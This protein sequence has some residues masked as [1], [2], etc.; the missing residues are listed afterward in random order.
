MFE[1]V[2]RV[3]FGRYAA[4]VDRFRKGP[5]E[6]P[7]S[8]SWLVSFVAARDADLIVVQHLLL[9][10]NAHINF[11]L[12]VAIA[13]CVTP[14]QMPAFR[15]DFEYLNEVFRGV[16]HTTVA[17]VSR[18][19]RVLSWVGC[20]T[21]RGE[22]ILI[23]FSLRRAR[24][25]AWKAAGELAAMTPDQ[26]T[27]AIAERDAAV[28][29]VAGIIMD[30]GWFG[31]AMVAAIHHFEK[32]D[33]VGSSATCWR[34]EDHR[35]R[36]NSADDCLASGP[37]VPKKKVAILGGGQAALTVALQLTDPANPRHDDYDITIYQLG[38]RLGGK[39]ATGR[40]VN[41]PW[42]AERIE[43][44]GLHT[45]FGFYDNSFRQMRVVFG[46][47][48]R[49]AGTP[50]AT[51]DEAFEGVNEM[52]FV[53]QIRGQPRIWTL[54]NPTNGQAAWRRWHVAGAVGLRPDGSRTHR[55][56]ADRFESAVGQPGPAPA[57]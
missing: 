40:P 45:W 3:F 34:R 37:A 46:D 39:G 28:A 38:W 11:D 14:A 33:V 30:P 4:A 43:E 49:P 57:G 27:A 48:D 21:G 41:R 42:D 52:V 24:E 55:A 54:H 47:L 23:G 22:D 53:E 2:S 12:A 1:Q 17:N 16:I 31:R 26:R 36:R 8:A 20:V 44:H 56:P 35:D 6:P 7:P 9:G 13:E 50:L 32:R 51:F 15:Q 18:L 19:S 10:A 25:G 5:P 29:G